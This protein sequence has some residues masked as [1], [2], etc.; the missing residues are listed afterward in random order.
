[1]SAAPETGPSGQSLRDRVLD[2][3]ALLGGTATTFEV[4]AKVQAPGR[5]VLYKSAHN[6]LNNLA[7]ESPP[8][9]TALG[10]ACQGPGVPR[11]WRLGAPEG[12]EGGRL[13]GFPPREVPQDE[14]PGR[15]PLHE[16]CGFLGDSVG[17]FW[18]C[19]APGQRRRLGG[20]A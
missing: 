15:A 12:A 3:L 10:D 16:R 8:Q 2:A 20:A 13:P 4:H 5:P 9:V 6:T 14:V 19:V 18:V 1:M 7:R 11:T 17:H